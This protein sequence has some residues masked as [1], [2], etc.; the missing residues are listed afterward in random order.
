VRGVS[1]A[2]ASEDGGVWEF[3]VVFDRAL[4]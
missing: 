2:V 1:G 3:M 4:K